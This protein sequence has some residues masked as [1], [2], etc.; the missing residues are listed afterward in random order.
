MSKKIYVGEIEGEPTKPYKI[1]RKRLDG[2][3]IGEAL[4]E[5]DTL[6][7]VKNY[8]KSRDFNYQVQYKRKNIDW[9]K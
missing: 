1:Y 2:E 4:A 8:D 6:E 7:E 9:P 3:I 5:Y